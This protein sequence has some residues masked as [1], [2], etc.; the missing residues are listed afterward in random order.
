[1]LPPDLPTT[2]GFTPPTA[3]A[4]EPAPVL[5]AAS[6]PQLPHRPAFVG[7]TFAVANTPPTVTAPLPPPETAPTAQA[8]PPDLE[9][10]DELDADESLNG[11][12]PPALPSPRP[13]SFPARLSPAKP[14][15]GATEGGPLHNGWTHSVGAAGATGPVGAEAGSR[16]PEWAS[17]SATGPEP[18]GGDVGPGASSVSSP[19]TGE[20]RAGAGRSA[21]YGTGAGKS[22]KSSCANCHHRK[23]K[24]DQHRPA[25]SS[26]QRKGHTC[27]YLE[28]DESYRNHQPHR[29]TKSLP[30][31]AAIP[32]PAPKPQESTTS[33]SVP[34]SSFA[35]NA[36]SEWGSEWGHPRLVPG[37][38]KPSPT[39]HRSATPEKPERKKK[40]EDIREKI[41]NGYDT[42]SEEDI[43][44]E[45]V[46][47]QDVD[48]ELAALVENEIDELAD[49]AQNDRKSQKRSVSVD[50]DINGELL[51]LA[52]GP[53]KKKKKKRPAMQPPLPQMA[54]HSSM[55]VIPQLPPNAPLLH[56]SIRTAPPPIMSSRQVSASMQSFPP[57]PGTSN[58]V[59]SHLPQRSISNHIS[60][61]DDPYSFPIQNLALSLPTAEAQGILLRGFWQDPM[62]TEGI[63]LLQ[64]QFHDDYARMMKRLPTRATHNDATTLALLYLILACALRIMPE[65]TSRLLLA[66]QNNTPVPR[67]LSRIISGQPPSAVDPSPLDHRYLDHAEACMTFAKQW[68]HPNI[69][70]VVYKLV[71][72]RYHNLWDKDER[73]ISSAAAD[74]ANGIK[75]A[76][77]QGLG[78][79][80]H[81]LQQADR[82]LRRRL[83]WALYSAD[84]Q[85]SFESHAPYTIV[86]VHLGINYPTA[87]SDAEL[88]A[89]P[90]SLLALPT[91][92]DGVP[93]ENTAFLLQ[94]QL[95]RRLTSILDAFATIGPP[96]VEHE[97]IL[98]YDAT[99]DGY[100]ESLPPAFRVFPATNTNWDALMPFLPVQRVRLHAM[101]FAFRTGIHRTHL[102]KYLQPQ[103]PIG[104]RQVI[105]SICMS[106]LRVQRSAKM[107]DP[108]IGLR[109]FSPPTVFE[110]AAVLGMIMYVDKMLMA[111]VA[112]AAG[113]TTG[114][115]QRTVEYMGMRSA[116]ADA[117]ELLDM[118]VSGPAG[119]VSVAKKGAQVVRAMLGV[120]DGPLDLNAQ[121]AQ[122]QVNGNGDSPVKAPEGNGPPN[123][124]VYPP[125]PQPQTQTQL[126]A[127]GPTGQSAGAGAGSE[128]Q[129]RASSP[130]SI[131][132]ASTAFRPPRTTPP[133]HTGTPGGPGTPT[134][135]HQ[136]QAQAAAAAA[137][138]QGIA[139]GQ[140]GPHAQKV[141]G[142]LAAIQGLEGSGVVMDGLLKEPHWNGAWDRVVG[143]M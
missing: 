27:K 13:A 75:S 26:C 119:G 135:G 104:V 108:T 110:N 74:L 94:V 109:L 120:I 20:G 124:S 107:L 121:L 85:Y 59:A 77:G 29:F 9:E 33:N 72:W 128:N 25:C 82:E 18:V 76:Q 127:D 88:F 28:E 6:L 64:A 14:A 112:L 103:A 96:H 132:S 53:P 19:P 73:N 86:D 46:K 5:S 34:L 80:W 24:C 41:L 21:G 97:R 140:L 55:Q 106:S 57:T 2:K 52:S 36:Q 45:E 11:S 137:A 90:A 142:W 113:A 62:L 95:V 23:I 71:L 56:R 8:P 38:S 10:E 60:P 17:A 54:P 50:D 42:D 7:P 79:E 139:Q 44:K 49:D 30:L 122:V 81:G 102:A 125:P 32:D 87:L 123:G 116:V 39:A 66:A 31:A 48:G 117:L 69:M 133:T 143:S 114:P 100:Q 136:T 138:A 98:S 130:I 22:R 43:P 12:A 65:D 78:K 93:T 37:P 92:T 4:L 61:G 134:H 16:K 1:M 40:K 15:L 115:A 91:S 118:T 126:A 70:L 51:E 105:S 89:A 67:S 83:V 68:D 84:R 99:L 101:L 63:A 58:P 131:Y 141:V 3:H 47:K 111:D 129:T 35:M